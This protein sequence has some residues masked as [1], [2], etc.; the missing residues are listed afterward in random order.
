MT[1]A[2]REAICSTIERQ[3][4]AFQRD[5]AAEAFSLASPGIQ[6]QF[7]TPEKFMRM[8]RVSYPSVYRPRAVVFQETIEVEGL[9]AQKVMLMSPEGKLVVA[10]YLMQ[11]QPDGNWQIHGCV[12]LPV[13]K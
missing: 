2:D 11:Q 9:P 12:L 13:E 3:L 8:V 4:A 6:S 7:A 1:P 10:L 5:D